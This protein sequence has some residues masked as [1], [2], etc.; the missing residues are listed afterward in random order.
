M[1]SERLTL[2]SSCSLTLAAVIST[3]YPRGSR[4][5]RSLLPTITRYWA[6][7]RRIYITLT[8]ICWVSTA[9]KRSAER[10]QPI[11][12][13]RRSIRRTWTC[14]HSPRSEEHTSELQSRFDL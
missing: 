5:E 13:Q 7:L 4:I 14:P 2:T 12:S 10:E 3:L 8:P 9:L 6:R 11:F 1:R